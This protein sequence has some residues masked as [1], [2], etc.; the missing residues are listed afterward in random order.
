[1]KRNFI[2]LLF[3]AI[4]MMAT[5]PICSQTTDILKKASAQVKKD[6]GIIVGFVISN[7]DTSDKGTLKISGKKFYSE[8]NGLMTWFDGKNMWSYV[9]ENNEVNLTEP[10]INEV[11]K[12]NPYYFL[13]YYKKGYDVTKGNSISS[14]YEV[15]L[16][17][18]NSKT[19][20]NKILVRVGKS[21]YRPKYLKVTTNKGQQLEITVTSY[22]FGQKFAD[23]TFKFDKK[24]YPKAEV[25]DLR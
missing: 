16:I 10:T 1:M 7:G 14:Y 2:R 6:G 3:A 21:D 13:D 8:I 17:A 18:Q 24:K 4:S 11:A 22:K 12:I 20:M 19:S 25:I 15:V 9:K 23:S 5:L